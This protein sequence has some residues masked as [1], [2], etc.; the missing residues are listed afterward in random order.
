VKN[1]I[2]D[3]ATEHFEIA[4]YNFLILT[5]TALG[6]KEIAATCKAILKEEKA[7]AAALDGQL[8]AVNAAYLATLDDGEKEDASKPHSSG[9][10]PKLKSRKSPAMR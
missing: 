2:A 8:Q 1:A 4:C 6:E 7:M 9:R 10:K 3:F 5:A